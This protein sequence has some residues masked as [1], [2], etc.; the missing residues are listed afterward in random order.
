MNL[1]VSEL[2]KASL[3]LEAHRRGFR[4]IAA[5]ASSTHL[6]ID[7]VADWVNLLNLKV[8]NPRHLNP[9]QEGFELPGFADLNR[10]N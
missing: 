4:S 6:R 7:D 3:V 5:I 10:M 8:T 9:R 2:R 1:F